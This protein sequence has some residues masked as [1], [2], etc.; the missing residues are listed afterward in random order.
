MKFTGG[1][2]LNFLKTKIAV[3]L[4]LCIHKG[5]PSYRRSLQPSK[6][7][8]HPALQN[9]KFLNFF[10]FWWAI[11]ALLC[12]DPDACPLTL[13]NPDPVSETLAL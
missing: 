7:R 6:R 2:I 1:K 13:L 11:F 12:P 4:S 8:E 5:R 3:Y 10:L 9:M